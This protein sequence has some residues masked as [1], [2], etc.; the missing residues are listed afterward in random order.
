LKEGISEYAFTFLFSYA[1]WSEIRSK[2]KPSLSRDEV[3]EELAK[4]NQSE[5]AAETTQNAK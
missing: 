3:D 2:K 4:D 1:L 5:E